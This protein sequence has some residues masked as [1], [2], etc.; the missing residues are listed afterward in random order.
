MTFDGT[1]S[2]LTANSNAADMALTMNMDMT[3][4]M[5]TLA[6]MQGVTPGD[7]GITADKMKMNMDMAVKMDMAAGQYYF[8]YG[9]EM[10]TQLGLP[11][12]AWLSMDLGESLAQSGLDL[13]SL[14][15]FDLD[16][17]LKATLA[18]YSLDG[19]SEN[20]YTELLGVLNS[21][22]TALSDEGFQKVDG[23]YKTDFA[24]NQDGTTITL[25]LALTTDRKSNVV[26]YS[27]KGDA[28]VTLP[29]E[30]TT[31]LTQSGIQGADKLTLTLDTAVDAKNRATTAVGLA[32]GQALVMDME[33][34][35][36]YTAT[37]KVPVTALPEGAVVVDMNTLLAGMAVNQTPDQA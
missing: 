28:S 33:V 4:M 6:A 27:L 8:Q 22:S 15:Q 31:L 13:E 14:K 23:G 24:L 10:N 1:L 30:L 21:L 36:T 17:L 26:G 16:Q 7:M 29:P 20:G 5:T 35:C 19:K 32:V 37:D 3:G 11:A 9:D 34:D 18:T 2:G 12:G 25:A